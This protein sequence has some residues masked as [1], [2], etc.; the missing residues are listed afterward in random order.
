MT[1]VTAPERRVDSAGAPRPPRT[2]RTLPARMQV[3]VATLVTISCAVLSYAVWR[4]PHDEL[5]AFV[6]LLALSTL[7]AAVKVALPLTQG[8]STLSL[9]YVV[10]FGALLVLGPWLTVPIGIARSEE[11]RVGKECRSRWSPYH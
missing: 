8:G 9:S 4:M 1:V 11:R 3:Y 5:P 10:N 6:I 7:T 2:F